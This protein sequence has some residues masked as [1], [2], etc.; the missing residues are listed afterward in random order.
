M[1]GKA[2][3]LRLRGGLE[4]IKAKSAVNTAFIVAAL[5]FAF[6]RAARGLLTAF[7]SLL[8]L[9]YVR[10][11]PAARGERWLRARFARPPAPAPRAAWRVVAGNAPKGSKR[12]GGRKK[13]SG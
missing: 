4:L 8:C 13:T 1:S 11:L 3:S 9:M 6:V 2:V 7:A 5:P 10:H 12:M